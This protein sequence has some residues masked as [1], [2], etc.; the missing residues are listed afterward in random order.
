MNKKQ[1]KLLIKWSENEIREWV[2]FLDLLH[3]KLNDKKSKKN[4]VS[5]KRK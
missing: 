1:L 5:R 2:S 4:K 3:K